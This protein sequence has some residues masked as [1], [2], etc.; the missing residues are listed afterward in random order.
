MSQTIQ[1]STGARAELL[2]LRGEQ[3]R[4][5]RVS[6]IPGGCSGLSYRMAFDTVQ[7]AFDEAVFDQEGLKV[8]A[9]KESVRNLYGLSI[10]FSEDLLRGG[11]R[12]TNPNAP[13]SCGCGNSFSV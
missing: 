2:R 3:E 5:L 10:D 13:A 6:V 8:I 4:F 7:T 9:D 11:F 1:I 12:F